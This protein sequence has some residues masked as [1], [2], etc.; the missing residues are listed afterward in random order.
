MADNIPD[1][2][3]LIV[4]KEFHL[5]DYLHVVQRRWRIALI[6]FVLVFV[7][8]AVYSF[9]QIPQ[10]QSSVKLRIGYKADASAQVLGKSLENRYSVESEIQVL[11]S[12]AM[13][14]M[15]ARKGPFDWRVEPLDK[16]LR[17]HLRALEMPADVTALSLELTT[18]ETY[19]L[20]AAD[21][22]ELL[23]GV[24][25]EAAVAGEL[26]AQI[27]LLKGRKG[28]KANLQRIGPEA[29]VSRVASGVSVSELNE[30]TNILLLTVRGPDPVLTADAANARAEAYYENSRAS[31]TLE[32][33]AILE[34]IDQQLGG[35]SGDLDQ[36]EQAY[37]EFRIS[38][39]L[40][41]LSPEG[42]SLVDA[43]VKL[44]TEKAELKLL[45]GS[46][47]GFLNE[48]SWTSYD[49]TAVE[50]VPGVNEAVKELLD[51]RSNRIELL[52]IYTTA[53]PDVVETDAQMHKLREQIFTS[54]ILFRK[55]I[56]QQISD[57]DKAL[58]NL[59][60]RLEQ[61]PE[62][63]LEMVRLTRAN[64]VN[65]N[66]YSYLLQRQQE[67]RIQAASTSGNVEIIDRA[68][69]PTAPFSPNRKKQL[70]LGFLLGALL[71]L[72]LTFLLDYLDRTIKD[73]E[74]V[75]DKLGLPVVGTIPRIKSAEEG[76]QGQL[77]THLDPMSAAAESFLALR[78]NLLYTITNQKHKTVLLTS[79]LPDEGKSTVSVN[80]AA[81][82]AQTGAK[83]LL[84][85]CDLR[86]PSL[87][88][89]LDQQGTPGLTDLLINGDKGALRKIS[90]LG[91]DFIPG[92]TEPPNPTQIL[93]SEQMQRFLASVNQQYD[94]VILDAP[95]LLPVADA[96]ILA[97]RVD[98]NVMVIESCR[99]PEKI[100]KRALKALQTH[101]AEIAGVVLNDKSGKGAKYYGD[102]SYYDGKYYQ[103]YYRRDEPA[104][105]LPIWKR[106][107]NRVWSFING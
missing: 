87:Y 11:S 62:E 33:N 37:Q 19:L 15:A 27:T 103:G 71:G 69:I 106:T 85:G 70:T 59:T 36:S 45:N 73:E 86:R 68:Q 98:L 43:A 101:G 96:L 34:F 44:E 13:A 4:E 99:I 81:T 5:L 49:F 75:Q 57:L 32:A 29:A 82:L 21:G 61:F 102:Y 84:V 42:Q 24:S 65:A 23:S 8:V 14:E 48:Y 3:P 91:L 28:D 40:E 52:R 67:A 104:P 22:R 54:A 39:G 26:K 30:G 12:Y 31:R 47:N 105:V 88:Q 76:D 25:G 72:G 80:L 6:V 60:G 20:R 9:L 58:A 77:I 50:E 74:D 1:N 35:L 90:S 18:P 46:I 79:C 16:S 10:Y 97:S 56:A 51:L 41:R 17:L 66:L 7:T 92:G 89:A 2:S 93:N 95:P 64:Q 100:A 94:Y 78:T 83:T 63:E 38:T 55:R 107:L 53:H